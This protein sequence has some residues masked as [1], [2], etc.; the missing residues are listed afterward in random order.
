MGRQNVWKWAICSAS[1]LLAVL[2]FLLLD[3]LKQ[4]ITH[5]AYVID[6]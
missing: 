3:V 4:S 2:V 1:P 6:D 5:V